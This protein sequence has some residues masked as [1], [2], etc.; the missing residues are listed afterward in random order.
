MEAV[1]L[2][3]TGETAAF[4]GCRHV[5]NIPNGKETHIERLPNA[6]LCAIIGLH[7]TQVFHL[8]DPFEVAD[9]RLVELFGLFVSDLH[10][11]IAIPIG[12]LDLCDIAGAGRH[13]RSP[14]YRARAADHATHS[15]LGSE[16]ALDHEPV[17][18]PCAK[19]RV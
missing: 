1:A 6:E 16:Q 13:Q 14:D 19:A 17:L 11:V 4:R 15:Q 2:H 9:L 5:H 8:R 7:L 10:S 18:R 3:H 12:R